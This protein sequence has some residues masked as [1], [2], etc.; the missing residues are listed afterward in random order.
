[1]VLVG[2]D[3]G[4]TDV[5]VDDVPIGG[6]CG[7]VLIGVPEPAEDVCGGCVGLVNVSGLVDVGL[8]ASVVSGCPV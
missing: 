5:S 8:S 7:E 4:G 6:G 3:G 1:M 2:E